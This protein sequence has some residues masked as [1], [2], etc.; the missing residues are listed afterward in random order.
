MIF[1]STTIFTIRLITS[2]SLNSLKQ[3]RYLIS[4]LVCLITKIEC[5]KF[6]LSKSVRIYDLKS[7]YSLAEI[8][9]INNLNLITNKL[10]LSNN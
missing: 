5:V 1:L 8:P 4:K 7:N 2:S 6:S 10:V 9:V 3:V